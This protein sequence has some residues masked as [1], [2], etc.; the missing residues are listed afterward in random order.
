MSCTSDSTPFLLVPSSQ[1]TALLIASFLLR[2]LPWSL[3]FF[4]LLF[5]RRF[6]TSALS[7]FSLSL[8]LYEVVATLLIKAFRCFLLC[9]QRWVATST[10][11]AANSR[12]SIASRLSIPPVNCSV[13]VEVDESGICAAYS[14]I[15]S[16]SKMSST[17]GPGGSPSSGRWDS[18]VLCVR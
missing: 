16:S 7:S 3:L 8:L 13:A 18:E 6:K 4:R 5:A 11:M 1:V 15:I 12:P 17:V 10:K 2:C 14:L 9:T